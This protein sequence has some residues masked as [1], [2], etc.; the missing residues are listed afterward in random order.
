MSF[1]PICS[2]VFFTRRLLG[3]LKQSAS[4]NFIASGGR[5]SENLLRATTIRVLVVVN[6]FIVLEL[7]GSLI[8][9]VGTMRKYG[10]FKGKIDYVTYLY[11]LT[12]FYFLGVVNSFVNFYVYCI[13]GSRFRQTLWTLLRLPVKKLE[14]Q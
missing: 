9:I 6:V 7:P 11:F 2:L 14:L 3:A 10:Y 8:Q 4:I 12:T 1:I 13:T 5:A